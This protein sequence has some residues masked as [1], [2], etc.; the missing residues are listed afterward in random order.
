MMTRRAGALLLIGALGAA[1]A[2]PSGG[3]QAQA[4]DVE[5]RA[6]LAEMVEAARQ[7]FPRPAGLAAPEVAELMRTGGAVLIDVRSSEERAVSMIPGAMGVDEFRADPERF[8]GQTVVAYCT[9]GYRSAQFA[10]EM[11][12]AGIEVLNFE[13]SILAWVHNGGALEDANGPTTRLHVYGDRWN[14]A[15]AGIQTVW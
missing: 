1:C 5:K 6:T 2:A 15:P 12:E 3:A 4:T 7:E 8:A 9:I 11:A 13:G 10:T 14:L